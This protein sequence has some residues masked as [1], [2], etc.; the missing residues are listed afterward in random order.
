MS[1]H[2]DIH[3]STLKH[4]NLS[5][6]FNLFT[7][8]LTQPFDDS[9]DLE[10]TFLHQDNTTN[11]MISETGTVAAVL[12]WFDL[13]LSQ[14]VRYSTLDSSSHIHQAAFIQREPLEV[15]AGMELEMRSLC[16]NSCLRVT[17]LLNE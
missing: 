10:I 5:T 16:K 7:F 4:Q 8:D 15:N 9:G 2:V 17:L 13:Q 3:L 11:V 12:Y 6:P 14:T 1:H